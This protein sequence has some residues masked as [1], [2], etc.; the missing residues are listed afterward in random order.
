MANFAILRSEA[1]K[2][3]KTGEKQYVVCLLCIWH[4]KKYVFFGVTLDFL[5][6]RLYLAHFVCV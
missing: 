4:N 5:F 3:L 2:R 6:C 1:K